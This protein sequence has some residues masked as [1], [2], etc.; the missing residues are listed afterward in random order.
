MARSVL[1]SEKAFRKAELPP[2]AVHNNFQII[3]PNMM[4]LM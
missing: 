3:V 2:G 1:F 4:G